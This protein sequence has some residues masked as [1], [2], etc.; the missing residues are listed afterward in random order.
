VPSAQTI[1]DTSVRD[2]GRDDPTPGV[3]LV[4]AGTAP[5]LRAVALER[6]LLAIG[7]DDPL[8]ATLDDERLSRHHAVI[9]SGG[10]R[11]VVRDL[12]SRNGTF[13]DGVRVDGW[14]EARDGCVVR[15]GGTIVLLHADVAPFAGARVEVREDLVQGPAFGAVVDA[16]AAASTAGAALFIQG[17]TG[18]GKELVARA[19]HAALLSRTAAFVA[20][21]C[22]AIPQGLAESL[23]FGSKRGAYSGA[24]GDVLGYVQA[25]DGGVLFL[26]E[27][28]E[29]DLGVQAKLLRF[30]ET[31]EIMPLGTST[32]IR[33]RLRLCSATH[34]DL[35]GEVAAGRFRSDLY[36]RLREA[37]VVVPPLRSRREEIPWLVSASL[38]GAR[39]G[40]STVPHPKLIEE[41]L[42]RPWPGNVRELVREIRQAARRAGQEDAVRPEHLHADAGR[43]LASPAA[44]VAGAPVA[45]APVAAA[46]VAAAPVAAAPVAAAPVA[47]A[48]VAV[49]PAG[50]E[51]AASRSDI[52]A[53]LERAGGNIS[54]AAR[55]LGL[56]RTQ[57]RR[58]MVKLGLSGSRT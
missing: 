41:C 21:N 42:L 2:P 24:A 33:V 37:E 8:G 53:A 35:R 55:A 17:E 34:R 57:L 30:I 11:W 45:G 16:A 51:V 26:D 50:T 56:H 38:A 28:G 18:T 25:A 47:A 27:V 3:L 22:A 39:E 31:R 29:L 13:V 40:R 46:P 4:Q 9:E 5:M 32:A 20:V 7:R 1:D 44:P 49:G 54:A 23:L 14:R 10:A 52:E 19:F 48:P 6:G 58:M 15:A 36:F 12:S 43:P